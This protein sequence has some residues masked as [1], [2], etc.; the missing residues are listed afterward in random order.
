MEVSA[1][2]SG[3]CA[4]GGLMGYIRRGSVMSAVG[5]LVIALGYGYAAMLFKT[6]AEADQGRLVALGTSALLSGVMTVRYLKTLKP[7]PLV[8]TIVG[9]GAF[10]FFAVSD[11]VA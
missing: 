8:L 5:G 1:V 7:M 10:V 4:I 9:I 3:V 2:L 11:Q 6:P